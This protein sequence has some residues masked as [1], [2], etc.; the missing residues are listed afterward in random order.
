MR[1]KKRLGQ[2]FLRDQSL[3]QRIVDVFAPH[4]QD[5]VVEIGPGEG[6][7]TRELA[8]RVD[9]LHVI[10]LDSDLCR[11]LAQDPCLSHVHVHHADALHFPLC[12]LIEPGR[13]LRLIGN[14]PYNISTPLLFR[15]FDLRQCL[16]DMLFMFQREVVVRMLAPPGGKEYGRLSVMS[17]LFCQARH[18][19]EAPPSAFWPAPRV[20]SAVVHLTPR[21]TLPLP[22]AQVQLFEEVVR[23]AF[24]QRRKTLRNSLRNVLDE[25]SLQR[26]GIDPVRRA[27]TLSLAEFLMVTEAAWRCLGHD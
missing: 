17:Q 20:H 7:L 6:V 11:Q 2:H 15:L 9:T 16:Q 4:P 27:E 18:V 25:A 19:L 22:G 3:V 1:P 24:G 5:L 21:D 26:I 12:D 23:N 8:T 10:E 13:R 14:L